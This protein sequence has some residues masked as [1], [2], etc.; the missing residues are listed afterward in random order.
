MKNKSITIELT[1]EESQ[2]L[3]FLLTDYVNKVA[4]DIRNARTVCEKIV[5]ELKGEK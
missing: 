4:D 2:F 1:T 3:L 5:K